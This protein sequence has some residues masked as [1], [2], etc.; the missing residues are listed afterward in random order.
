M[1][2]GYTE[3]NAYNQDLDTRI[4]EYFDLDLEREYKAFELCQIYAS[5]PTFIYEVWK[6]ENAEATERRYALFIKGAEKYL[7][8]SSHFKQ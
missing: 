4:V 2:P 5:D 1:I 6:E 7:N 3:K 8:V